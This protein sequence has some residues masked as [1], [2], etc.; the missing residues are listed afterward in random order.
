MFTIDVITL[1]PEVF[2]PF[3]GLSIVGRAVERG[4]CD[5]S[6]PPSAR[7]ARRRRAR[8][9]P[10]VRRRPG[11]V[12]RLEPI[13]RALDRILA[14]APPGRATGDR[15][16]EPERASVSP[17][18]RPALRRPRPPDRDLRP[19]RGYRRPAGQPVSD[20]GV[21]PRRLRAHRRRNSGPG[22]RRRDRPSSRGRDPAGIAGKRILLGRPARYPSYTRPP[23][24]RGVAVPDVLLSGD[25]AKIAALAARTIAPEN[26]RSPK[27]PARG[28]GYPGV[29]RG[30]GSVIVFGGCGAGLDARLF[31]APP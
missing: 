19:L 23:V 4:P 17:K 21:S 30:W 2:A 25:H 24:F 6:L 20:R 22:D 31:V 5:D 10:A 16:S 29:A 13:A 27:R 18:R 11:M 3:V 9:R 12:M 1:F 7:G 26:R 8:R 14:Q 28:S 15:R